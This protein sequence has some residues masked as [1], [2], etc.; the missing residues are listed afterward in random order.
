[1]IRDEKT[2]RQWEAEWQRSTPADPETNLRVFWTLL[3]MARAAGAWPPANPL[4]GLENDIRLARRINTYVPPPG[5]T[6]E[7]AG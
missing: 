2:W 1:M 7:D 5:K 3:E 6:R 4:E